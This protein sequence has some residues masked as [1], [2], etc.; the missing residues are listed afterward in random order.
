MIE[1]F[2]QSLWSVPTSDMVNVFDPWNARSPDDIDEDAVQGR[3]QRLREHLSHARPR[4]LCVGEA[5]GANGCRVSGIP[6]TSERLLLDGSIPG[7]PR[8]CDRLTDRRLPY[9][10]QSATIVWGALYEAGIAES[11]VLWNAFPWHP[12]QPD[13]S[14]KNRTPTRGERRLGLV[15]LKELVEVLPDVVVAAVGKKACASMA[16]I[17]VSAHELR[18]P[19]NGGA[20]LFRRQL[21]EL[22]S[23]L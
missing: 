23:R 5:P 4:L 12:H 2:L 7:V 13:N 20:S 21:A 6:F 1:S 17:G 10:E 18:H 15:L 3:R 22:A 8:L 16:D 9:R 11:T 19:A 14:L